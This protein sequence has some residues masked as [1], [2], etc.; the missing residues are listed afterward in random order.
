MPRPTIE[1]TISYSRLARCRRITLAEA[2]DRFMSRNSILFNFSSTRVLRNS[3]Q[4]I[5]A[6]LVKPWC[7]DCAKECFNIMFI[8]TLQN[9]LNAFEDWTVRAIRSGL[10]RLQNPP[11]EKRCHFCGNIMLDLS[12]EIPFESRMENVMARLEGRR[13]PQ[14]M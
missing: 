7:W 3:N 11:H 4:E 10:R 14:E 13:Q 9:R 8:P 1:Y 5:I 12:F 6:G 2:Y